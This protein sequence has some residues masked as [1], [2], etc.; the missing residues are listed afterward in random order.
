MYIYSLAP[1]Y[2]KMVTLG[3]LATTAPPTG[4]ALKKLVVSV[5]YQDSAFATPQRHWKMMSMG[6]ATLTRSMVS[7]FTKESQR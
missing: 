2:A 5:I 1:V 7:D 3:K 4:L 6:F